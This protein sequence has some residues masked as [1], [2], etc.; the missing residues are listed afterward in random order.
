MKIFHCP[1]RRA[2]ANAD[3]T[4]VQASRLSYLIE[5]SGGIAALLK[6]IPPRAQETPGAK[7]RWII[8]KPRPTNEKLGHEIARQLWEASLS[9]PT[10]RNPPRGLGRAR[11][12]CTPVHNA[13]GW[14]LDSNW[15]RNWWR[16]KARAICFLPDFIEKLACLLL[17]GRFWNSS[18]RRI[19]R[20]VDYQRR[21]LLQ[22]QSRT[23]LTAG[24]KLTTKSDERRMQVIEKS[25]QCDSLHN[26]FVYFVKIDD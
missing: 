3:K 23:N 7:R 10:H 8:N 18:R 25:L 9:P 6:Q 12:N 24:T 2:A 22:V 5:D 17:G 16:D 19:D 21:L 11:C 13:S 1:N 20:R 14:A 26:L 15:F 4:N